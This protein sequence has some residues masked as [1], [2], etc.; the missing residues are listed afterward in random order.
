MKDKLMLQQSRLDSSAGRRLNLVAS[1]C[2]HVSPASE[3]RSDAH[4]GLKNKLPFVDLPSGCK[5][6]FLLE[7]RGAVAMETIEYR[8]V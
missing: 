1:S 4:A 8:L 7:V 3:A 6:L 5:C 2:F